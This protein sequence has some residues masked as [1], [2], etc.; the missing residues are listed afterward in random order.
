MF[1][2]G[3]GR[4]LE[5]LEQQHTTNN[6]SNIQ[7]F[8]PVIGILPNVRI[9]KAESQYTLPT[10]GRIDWYSVKHLERSP[11]FGHSNFPD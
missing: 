4:R 7:I 11:E 5:L 6:C 3:Q 2:S 9:T 8:L 1:S 10:R